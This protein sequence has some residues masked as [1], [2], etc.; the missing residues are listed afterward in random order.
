MHFRFCGP[1]V[2]YYF[3]IS[4]WGSVPSNRLD[5]LF[6]AQKK[7]LRILFGDTEAYNDK[8]RTCARTRELSKQFLGPDHYKL[9]STKPIFSSNSILT[10]HNLFKYHV[11]V[12]TYKIIR[13][14]IPG[15]LFALYK[16]SK[17]VET[18]LQSQYTSCTFIDMS[19]T[20]WNHMRE[21]LS[22]NDFNITIS[23]LKAKTKQ[24][25]LVMQKAHDAQE[26]CTLNY[27]IPIINM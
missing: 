6:I 15:S 3:A 13:S 10:V 5:K 7:C 19:T 20:L 17:H 9:E 27:I 4:V 14:R 16:F 11:A 21:K 25:L 23:E 24:Y 18:R 1:C 26:W 8:F 2:L 22:I 12:A